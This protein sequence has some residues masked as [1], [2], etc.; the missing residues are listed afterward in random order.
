MMGHDWSCGSMDGLL[1][2]GEKSCSVGTYAPPVIL[3]G[4]PTDASCQ[5]SAASHGSMAPTGPIELCCK[6]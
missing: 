6:P 4:T 3:V 5:A 1:G 2:G